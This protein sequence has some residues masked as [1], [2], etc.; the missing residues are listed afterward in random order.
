M[1]IKVAKGQSLRSRLAALDACVEAR[2]WVGSKSLR[3]AYRTCQRGDWMLWLA[4]RVEEDRKV[5]VC[6]ACQC[7]RLSLVHVSAGET[8]PLKAIETA[9]AWCRGDAGVT[10]DDVREAAAY[11]AAAYAAAY[12]AAA[13]AAA[14]AAVSLRVSYSTNPTAH[15]TTT[16]Y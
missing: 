16:L 13:Y 3:T 1:K 4:G 15:T 11:A 10:L 12:A 9:E 7:A 2:N 8:R 6:A 14:Y 5:L